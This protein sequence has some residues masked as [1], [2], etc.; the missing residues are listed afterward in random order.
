MKQESE[1]KRKL[2]VVDDSVENL[3]LLINLLSTDYEL[4]IAKSGEKALELV[5]SNSDLDLILLDIIMPGGINGY[6]VCEK[7]K[8]TRNLKH[9]PIIFLTGLND[10]EDETLGLKLG[11]AD[12]ITKP[13]QAEIVLARIRT[14]L[15]LIEEKEKSRNLLE[16]L[17]PKNVIEEYKET[18]K[19]NP[20]IHENITILF[21]DLIDFTRTTSD[22]PVTILVEELSELFTEFDSIMSRNECMRIK[23]IG[24]GYMAVCGIIDR[25]DHAERIVQAGS[26]MIS[27]LEKRSG[28][29]R[30]RCRIGIHSG[31]AI[32]GIIGKQRFQF[33]LLGDDVNLA[34][35]VESNAMPMSLITTKS[36]IDK[37][38][39]DNFSY[40]SIGLHDLK[41]KGQ[42]ELFKIIVN[43]T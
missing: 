41:G 24:D 19:Y 2:L 33:D 27:Y 18:G 5:N 7:I 22:I 26:E 43:N 25:E 16:I 40:E 36:T 6:E 10:T 11:G 8:T 29:I 21:C 35:R 20:V 32:S 28:K 23:T 14:Q 39:Q 13:F 1:I 34:S 37:L 12:Y 3:K 15:R 42:L 17:L 38:P 9:I 31:K 30:W 4:V